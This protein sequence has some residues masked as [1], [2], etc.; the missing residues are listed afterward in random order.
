MNKDETSR[1]DRASEV[2]GFCGSQSL[3]VHHV[4]MYHMEGGVSGE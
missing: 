3:R 1:G 4:Q 2:T